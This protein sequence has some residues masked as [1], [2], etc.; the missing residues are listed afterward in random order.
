M[1]IDREMRK[2]EEGRFPAFLGKVESQGGGRSREGA[3]EEVALSF[4]PSAR[5]RA[6]EGASEGEMDLLVS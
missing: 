2:G 4:T 5:K 1:A 3:A 6:G